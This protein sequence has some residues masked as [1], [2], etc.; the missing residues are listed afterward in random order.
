VRAYLA[1]THRTGDTAEDLISY[2]E[3]A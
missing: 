2:S 3:E 1:G